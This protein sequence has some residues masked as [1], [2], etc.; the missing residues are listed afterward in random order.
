MD[1]SESGKALR[2]ARKLERQGFGRAAESMALMGAQAKMSEPSI[3]TE[4]YRNQQSALQKATQLEEQKTLEKI[5]YNSRK[6]HYMTS[7]FLLLYNLFQHYTFV[8]FARSYKYI[9]YQRR[10]I[11][12]KFQK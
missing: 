7:K 12:N 4:E 5:F 6:R 11:L 9:V 10:Y 1:E 8:L 3:K 2:M